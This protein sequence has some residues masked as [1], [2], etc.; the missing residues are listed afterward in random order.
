M[1]QQTVLVT[2]LTGFL[3]Q[4]IA[5]ELL[6][7]GYKVK[8]TVRSEKKAEIISKTFAG[9][10]LET[11]IVK[12]I[13]TSDLSDAMKG[14]TSIIHSASPYHFDVHN[15]VDD[16]LRPAVQG[17]LNVLTHAKA[18][19]I[20]QVII[21]SSFAAMNNNSAGGVFRDYVY[22]ENDW[23][24]LTEDDAKAGDP[25]RA[26]VYSASK[27]LAE[28]AAWNWR[29][30][31]IGAVDIVTINPPMIYGPPVATPLSPHD[32]NTSTQ[33]IY[34]LINHSKDIPKDR[35]PLFCDVRDCAKVHVMALKNKS[36]ANK[37][38]PICS[39]SFT[40]H[41]AVRYLYDERPE[42]RDRL[43]P[44]SPEAPPKRTVARIDT[45][46]VEDA[47]GMSF[48][49]WKKSLMD[50]IDNLVTNFPVQQNCTTV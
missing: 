3:S 8:G 35:L 29:E 38:L 46:L 14:C 15:A 23:S 5:C 9:R 27:K 13:A 48:I 19:G 4:H 26:P 24:P 6:S 18:A 33:N 2:G 12:D 43:P 16:M 21:T 42:L 1:L 34:E 10:A 47:F 20:T 40:W 32:L 49:P 45:H 22:T 17:T 31:H 11:V 25:M 7:Q 44:L 50:T 28:Q 30:E 39:D 41:E 36:V 37:R